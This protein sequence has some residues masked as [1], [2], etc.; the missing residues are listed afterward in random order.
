M[1]AAIV[2]IH[3]APHSGRFSI[4]HSGARRGKPPIGREGEKKRTSRRV[5]ERWSRVLAEFYVKRSLR[6]PA[7]WSG[8]R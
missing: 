6:A 8:S 2:L 3:G 4:Q 7:R 1:T 5:G